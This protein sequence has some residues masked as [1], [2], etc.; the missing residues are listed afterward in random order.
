LT[1]SEYTTMFW[2]AMKVVRLCSQGI[3]EGRLSRAEDRLARRLCELRDSS[4]PPK[5]GGAI[6]ADLRD[7]RRECPNAILQSLFEMAVLEIGSSPT[8]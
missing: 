3:D 8:V 5:H 1:T 4:P 2:R 6:T 7:L